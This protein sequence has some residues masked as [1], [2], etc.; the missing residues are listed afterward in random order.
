M[1]PMQVVIIAIVSF[2]LNTALVTVVT[3][4]VIEDVSNDLG[5]W[6]GAATASTVSSITTDFIIIV[7]PAQTGDASVAHQLEGE[8]QGP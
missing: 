1:R 5:Q 2:C 3:S 7:Y 4:S 8:S 6:V